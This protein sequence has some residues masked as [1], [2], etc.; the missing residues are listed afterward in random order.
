M[1]CIVVL[2][3]VIWLFAVP[4]DLV[5]FVVSWSGLGWF[6][7]GVS[8]SGTG[9]LWLV[10]DLVVGCFSADLRCFGYGLVTWFGYD[11]VF[12]VGLWRFRFM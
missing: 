7:V 11:G 10:L 12:V 5:D 3:V 9:V 6:C 1:T 4:L 2:V 8:C